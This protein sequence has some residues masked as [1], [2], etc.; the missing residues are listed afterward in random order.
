MLARELPTR[1]VP[2]AVRSAFPEP[3]DPGVLVPDSDTSREQTSPTDGRRAGG[4]RGRSSTAC[5]C[6]LKGGGTRE[7]SRC[8]TS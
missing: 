5:S 1:D 7:K 3:T 2:L 8:S 4:A 6:T